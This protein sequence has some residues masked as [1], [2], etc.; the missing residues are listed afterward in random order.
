MHHLHLSL[1]FSLS[2]AL[3]WYL[4]RQSFRYCSFKHH[5]VFGSRVMVLQKSIVK[6]RH[7]E[8]LLGHPKFGETPGD[9]GHKNFNIQK[10]VTFGRTWMFIIWLFVFWNCVVR[11]KNSFCIT[12]SLGNCPSWFYMVLVLAISMVRSCVPWNFPPCR[13]HEGAIGSN[14]RCSSK[15]SIHEDSQGNNSW[16]Y[17]IQGVNKSSNSPS[18]PYVSL[19]NQCFQT[20]CST[21][22][23]VSMV[24]HQVASQSSWINWRMNCFDAWIC[25][26]TRFL[27]HISL[28]HTIHEWYICLHLP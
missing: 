13:L 11:Q 27:G 17:R 7:F 23:V 2:L 9:Q 8:T 16:R 6:N 1:W 4:T 22:Q 15:L 12:F 19:N 28:P 24:V 5:F 3:R 25:T 20:V 14:W 26:W 18:P 21:S 10:M